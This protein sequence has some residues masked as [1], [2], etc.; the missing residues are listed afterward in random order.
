MLCSNA[1][2]VERDVHK[3][4]RDSHIRGEWYTALKQDIVAFLEQQRF[5]LKSEFLKHTL[6]IKK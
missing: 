5:V 2:N 1:Y 3:E 4:F 6:P